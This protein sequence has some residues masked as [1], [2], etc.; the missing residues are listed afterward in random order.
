MF[1]LHPGGVKPTM[2]ERTQ[3]VRNLMLMT[4]RAMDRYRSGA[5]CSQVLSRNLQTG[6]QPN[7]PSLPRVWLD[8][9]VA[10]PLMTSK[11]TYFMGGVWTLN[12]TCVSG[13]IML[14]RSLRMI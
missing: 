14:M 13:R 3:W 11:L 7:R 9:K 2:K 4:R 1:N 10:A 8:L 12:K 6:D 5:H